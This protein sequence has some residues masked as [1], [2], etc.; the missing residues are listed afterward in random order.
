MMDD[1]DRT[2]RENADETWIAKAAPRDTPVPQSR[3][4]RVRMANARRFRAPRQRPV[5][6]SDLVP[7]PRRQ[8]SIRKMNPGKSS[9][10]QPSKKANSNDEP[11]RSAQSTNKPCA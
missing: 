8:V 1:T 11:S 9:G 7:V 2:P 6:A 10:Q 3:L 5:P 4:M